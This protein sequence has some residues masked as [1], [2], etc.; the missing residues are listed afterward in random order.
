[1]VPYYTS[2]HTSRHREDTNRAM[3]GENPQTY[4]DIANVFCR[5]LRG[6]ISKVPWSQEELLL[7]TNELTDLLC[8]MN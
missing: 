5:F 1:M 3:W 4:S 2:D 6:E 7:E 8:E